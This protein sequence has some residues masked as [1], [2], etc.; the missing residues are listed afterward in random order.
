[1][2]RTAKGRRD[3]RRDEATLDAAEGVAPFLEVMFASERRIRPYNRYLCWELERHPLSESGVGGD[4]ILR[5]VA[6]VLQGTDGATREMFRFDG[7]AG[8]RCRD[9]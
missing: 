6:G 3:E 9:P 5:L 1:L 7:A 4:E 2:V 8:S